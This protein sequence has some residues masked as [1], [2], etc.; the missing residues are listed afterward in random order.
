M[1]INVQSSQDARKRPTPRR[2]KQKQLNLG[3]DSVSE[4]KPEEVILPTEQEA[5][6][7]E[8]PVVTEN[9]EQPVTSQAEVEEPI[10]PDQVSEKQEP[11]D[12][13]AEELAPKKATGKKGGL[14]LAKAGKKKKAGPPAEEV[15]AEIV[16]EWA[17]EFEEFN[18]SMTLSFALACIGIVIGMG[19]LGF[20]LGGHV[21]T[22]LQ[23]V[24]VL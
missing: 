12:T 7:V 8:E 23:N 9:V 1:K 5:A 2:G 18:T 15:E 19:A 4:P 10:A 24:G 11:D 21:I 16:E 14:G 20:T 22:L 13:F 6:A 3:A 17:P